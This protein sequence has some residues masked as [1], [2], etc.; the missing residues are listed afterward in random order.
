MGTRVG[1]DQSAISRIESGH[2]PRDKAT[3]LAIAEAY[4][5]TPAETRA[6]LELLFG[7]PT[8]PMTDSTPWGESLE[9]AYG[10]L[11]RARP[12]SPPPQFYITISSPSHRRSW[13]NWA[14]PLTPS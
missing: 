3:A 7:A 8:V 1:L 5:L 10:L 12:Q 14:H 13:G 4:R 6:W 2:K 9:R 11:E